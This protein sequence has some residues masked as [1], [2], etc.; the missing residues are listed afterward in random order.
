MSFTRPDHL[1][2]EFLPTF[3]F[4]NGH[5]QSSHDRQPVQC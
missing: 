2:H 1:E 3:T 4:S 5:D